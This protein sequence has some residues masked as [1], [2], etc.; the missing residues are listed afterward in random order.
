MILLTE[1]NATAAE[2]QWTERRGV[3]QSV[4]DE[5]K[6]GFFRTVTLGPAGVLVKR[7]DALVGIP[8]A[9]IIKLAAAADPRLNPPAA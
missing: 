9:D 8:L 5:P 6:P 1:L 2:G 7:G 4:H 3:L